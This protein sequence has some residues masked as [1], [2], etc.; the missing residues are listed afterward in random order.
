MQP[1][2]T[3]KP[4]GTKHNAIFIP[5]KTVPTL[6]VSAPYGQLRRRCIYRLSSGFAKKTMKFPA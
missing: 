5:F 4:C 6:M 3:G 1:L 2:R